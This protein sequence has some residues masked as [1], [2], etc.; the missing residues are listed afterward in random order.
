MT[1]QQ[2]I[3]NWRFSQSLFY[4]TIGFLLKA[5]FELT[6]LAIPIG[7]FLFVLTFLLGV[8]I[9]G[10]TGLPDQIQYPRLLSWI[11]LTAV[12]WSKLRC[13]TTDGLE[14][15]EIDPEAEVIQVEM[16]R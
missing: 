6:V 10:V 4:R 12:A 14:Y 9:S 3:V 1:W 7:I 16:R 11:I 8:P 5:G 15:R 13:F 2:R